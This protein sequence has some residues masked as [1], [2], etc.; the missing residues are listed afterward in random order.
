MTVTAKDLRF[1]VNMLFD[2]LGKGEDITITYRGKP[3]A[4]LISTDKNSDNN[5]KDNSLFGL[6]KDRDISV[7]DMVRGM[8][9]GR[10]FGI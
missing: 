4:K 9:R 5:K 6:W 8:R 7:D 3:K 10:D 2:V 1:N